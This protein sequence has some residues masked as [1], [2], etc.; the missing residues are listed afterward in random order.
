VKLVSIQAD[1]LAWVCQLVEERSGNVL[2]ESKSYL[3]ESRLAGLAESNGHACVDEF[4]QGL[5]KSLS[6]QVELEIV[7]AM[8][9]HE[10]F[11][12]R[13]AH[14]FEELRDKILPEL[15][16]NRQESKQLK[17]WC[18]ACAAGQEPFS[19]AMLL[20]THFG[21]SCD[22]TIKIIGS[23]FS[24][25]MIEQAKSATYSEIEMQRG[26]SQDRQRRFF[27][28]DG[29]RW[30]LDA[31][32]Q[33]MVDFRIVNLC[34]DPAPLPGL[35][36]ILMRNILIYLNDKSRDRIL[37]LVSDSLADDGLLIL[38]A[39]ETLHDQSEL[40]TRVDYR[41]PVYRRRDQS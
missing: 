15:L 8:L 12:F 6:R 17:I 11:F 22:W 39:T 27:R 30:K 25:G 7:E 4:I 31:A 29:L 3:I 9:T 26:L 34:T 35:D 10:S 33:D 5:R 37:K 21:T 41:I 24:R 13:D 14:Y 40:F 20:R 28:P 19:L 16:A 32:V 23:D 18:A 36:L 38:G 2:D 1:N